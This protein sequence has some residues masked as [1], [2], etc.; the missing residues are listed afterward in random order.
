MRHIRKSNGKVV[1]WADAVCINQQDIPERNRQLGIMSKIYRKAFRVIAYLGDESEDRDGELCLGLLEGL[2]TRRSALDGGIQEDIQYQ[3]EEFFKKHGTSALK[4]FFT[5][6]YFNRRWTIQERYYARGNLE[7]RA[8][9][10]RQHSLI[11]SKV[12]C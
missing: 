2:R 5:R 1:I 4:I 6:E 11:M 3:V 7:F 9:P 12:R 10:R 8:L